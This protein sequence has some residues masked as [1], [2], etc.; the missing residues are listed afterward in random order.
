[1]KGIIVVGIVLAMMYAHEHNVVH[2]S[3]CP[4][5]VLLDDAHHPIIYDFGCPPRQSLSTKRNIRKYT[6]PEARSIG[7]L[8]KKADVF[9]FVLMLYEVLVDHPDARAP[10]VR[11]MIASVEEETIP[12]FVKKLIA[13]GLAENPAMRPSFEEILDVLEENEF[14]IG[15]G[16]D[17]ASVDAF[18]T[19]VEESKAKK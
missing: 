1:M 13:D 4:D 7:R 18:A 12:S 6:P 3:L 19:W 16:V 8:S 14:K 5:C 15:A 10:D 17:T 2:G 11:R 9:A